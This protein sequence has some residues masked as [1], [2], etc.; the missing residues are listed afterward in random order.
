MDIADAEFWAVPN[1]AGL[2]TFSYAQL[3]AQLQSDTVAGGTFV[4][5]ADGGPYVSATAFDID[6][7][8][9]QATWES[10]GPTDSG[11]DH[12]WTALDL[13]PTN[14]TWID[15][16]LKLLGVDGANSTNLSIVIY[17]RKTGST[18]VSGGTSQIATCADRSTAAGDA[19][20]VAI[21]THKIPL[22]TALLFDFR[23]TTNFTGTNL[24]A[25]YLIGYG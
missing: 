13:L 18:L 22:S 15:V 24:A 9:T 1:S 5:A 2:P 16:R 6:A 8:V 19:Y 25:A 12:V 3:L 21:T 7:D 20:A 23:W 4:T 11:A 14:T 17:A 10:V